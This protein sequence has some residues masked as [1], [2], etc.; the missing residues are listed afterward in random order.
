M[1]FKI[2]YDIYHDYYKNSL[3]RLKWNSLLKMFEDVNEKEHDVDEE[4]MKYKVT[5]I[6]V[7]YVDKDDVKELGCR[8]C[9]EKHCWYYIHENENKHLLKKYRVVEE[10]LLRP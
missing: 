6:D 5:F 2:P 8:W 9:P 1:F 10:K 7:P 4:L 3:Y